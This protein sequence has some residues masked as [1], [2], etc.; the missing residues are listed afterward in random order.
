MFISYLSISISKNRDA[1][2]DFLR[3]PS[4]KNNHEELIKIYQK[5]IPTVDVVNEIF[6][7]NL[8]YVDGKLLLEKFNNLIKEPCPDEDHFNFTSYK[9]LKDILIELMDKKLTLHNAM[10]V[11]I[12]SLK[13]I[14]ILPKIKRDDGINILSFN[15]VDGVDYKLVCFCGIK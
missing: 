6:I 2:L 15:D 13:N 3:N 10:E 4:L 14:N 12:E 5:E 1:I 8:I 7:N 9:K 11:I